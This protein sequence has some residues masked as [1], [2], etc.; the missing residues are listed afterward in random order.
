MTINP[1]EII[2]SHDKENNVR[3]RFNPT[4]HSTLFE[5]EKT[6]PIEPAESVRSQRTTNTA[7]SKRSYHRKN[8]SELPAGEKILISPENPIPKMKS[9]NRESPFVHKS[10]NNIIE[11]DPTKRHGESSKPKMQSKNRSSPYVHKSDKNLIEF[12]PKKHD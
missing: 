11:F 9:K 1:Q 7:C 12:D 8:N 6:K 10:N 3:Q 5:H 4:Y 2:A